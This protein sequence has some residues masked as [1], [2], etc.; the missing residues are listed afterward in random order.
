M[1][2]FKIRRSIPFMRH[3]KVFNII[4]ALTFVAAVA[5][6]ATK[7]LHFSIE[8]TG[9]TVMEVTYKDEAK[10]DQIRTALNGIG[11][12]D[13]SVTKFGTSHDVLIRLPLKK[14]E[15]A[16]QNVEMTKQAEAV[17]TALKAQD[18]TAD[19]KRAEF[20]GGQVGKE[21]ATDGALALLAVC[22][23]IMVY[24]AFR[25]EWRFSVATIIANLHDVV[26]ILGFFALFQWEFSLPVLAAILA[27]LGYSVNESVVVFDR[28]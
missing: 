3:A 20:V 13:I 28:V 16:N 23:G 24:L 15:G 12:T 2:F 1:E 25:F 8:F 10:P 7:G 19:L 14:V 22:F 5:L 21:L 6:L 18:A 27:I 11:L 9:G 17:M 4:S 26:I